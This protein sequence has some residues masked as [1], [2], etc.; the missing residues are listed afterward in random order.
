MEEKA[1]LGNYDVTITNVT[2]SLAAFNLAGPLSRDVL[3][4]LCEDELSNDGFPFMHRRTIR[5]AGIRTQALRIS[6]TGEGPMC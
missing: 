1:R 2:D 6:A 5:V 4:E 3:T